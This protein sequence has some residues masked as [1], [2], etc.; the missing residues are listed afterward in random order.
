MSARVRER[1]GPRQL[2]PTCIVQPGVATRDDK[3]NVPKH[4]SCHLAPALTQT[5]R[6]RL[7]AYCRMK[8]IHLSSPTIL[9]ELGV[10]ESVRP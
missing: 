10:F 6:R 1:N 3:S 5:R 9:S 4:V 2:S 7:R 8:S